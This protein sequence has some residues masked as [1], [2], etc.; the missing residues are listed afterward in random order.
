MN[1][2]A[3]LSRC[4]LVFLA[5]APLSSRGRSAAPGCRANNHTA[6]SGNAR[7]RCGSA[8]DRT[9]PP[10]ACRRTRRGHWPC[11]PR[12]AHRQRGKT[13]LR[14]RTSTFE[15]PDFLLSVRLKPRRKRENKA[16]VNPASKR[17]L[18][19]RWATRQTLR[20]VSMFSTRSATVQLLSQ[21]RDNLFC[22]SM[23]ALGGRMIPTR[24]RAPMQFSP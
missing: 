15:S 18:N 1:R 5:L 24:Q 17:P 3:I 9:L 22:V 8:A 20:Q 10:A 2:G 7:Y 16:S 4:L 13:T 21:R 14:F 12:R 19:N 11:P 23:P 6:G